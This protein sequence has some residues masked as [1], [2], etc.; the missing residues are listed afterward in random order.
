MGERPY[1]HGNLRTGLI[2]EGLALIHEEG[3][4][5][6][7]LR[8]LARRLNVSPPATTTFPPPRPFWRRCGG[9]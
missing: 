1:H 5:N 2:E 4:G 9:T 8:K 6:F 3:R 7:S